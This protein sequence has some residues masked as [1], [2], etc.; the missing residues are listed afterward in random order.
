MLSRFNHVGLFVTLW[1]VA[2]HVP[3]S[4]GFP[5][6]EYLSGLP[7]AP[8]G[9]FPDPGIELISP[10]S[11][12]FHADSLPTEPPGKPQSGDYSNLNIVPRRN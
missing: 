8:P 4:I 7:C 6:Q 12:A 5:K 2:S 11:P 1:T 10:S 9:D 3:L